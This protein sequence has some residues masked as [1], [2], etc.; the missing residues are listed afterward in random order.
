MTNLQ[1]ICNAD[2]EYIKRLCNTVRSVCCTFADVLVKQEFS[3]CCWNVY[4][5]F[6]ETKCG[7]YF[8][9][10]KLHV[11]LLSKCR[12]VQRCVDA[13]IVPLDQMEEVLLIFYF[14]NNHL[15]IPCILFIW[16]SNAMCSVFL[17]F[18]EM[19]KINNL[20]KETVFFLFFFALGQWQQLYIY[21]RF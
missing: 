6:M 15:H 9:C 1:G 14:I 19:Q 5:R 21:I 8:P 11:F 20:F 17:Y 12:I 7:S 4:L 3:G 16:Y 10:N 18:N 2:V 13:V